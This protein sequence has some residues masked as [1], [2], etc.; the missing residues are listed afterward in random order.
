MAQ[1]KKSR[2]NK[3]NS[4]TL[5]FK[6]IILVSVLALLALWCYN[7]QTEVRSSLATLT[8]KI[9]SA[10]EGEKSAGTPPS[11]SS[12]AAS[13]SAPSQ[14]GESPASTPAHPESESAKSQPSAPQAAVP[15]VPDGLIQLPS[16]LAFPRCPAVKHAPDH[17]LRHFTDYDIC[18]RE[19]YEQAEWSAYQFLLIRKKLVV[20]RFH[21]AIQGHVVHVGS[22]AQE[23]RH[24]AYG[25]VNGSKA[26]ICQ[27]AF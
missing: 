25:L 8:Q 6:V 10:L 20:L 13:K 2:K 12:E 18:Y 17:E 9:E 27:N 16:E 21:L 15:V 3:N 24:L 14:S 4:I 23:F 22:G 1:K 11:E 7:H 19:S 5:A 26:Q